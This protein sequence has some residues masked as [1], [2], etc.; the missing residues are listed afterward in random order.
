MIAIVS[1]DAGGAE[2][3]SSYIKKY[4][5]NYLFVL[6]G[7]AVSIFQKKIGELEI[8]SLKDALK[9]AEEILTGTSWQSDLEKRA[10]LLARK[11]GKRSISFLDHWVNYKE[12]FIFQNQVTLPDEIWTGDDDAFQLA[13]KIFPETLIRRKENPYFE[14][15]KNEL[16]IYKKEKKS[17]EGDRIL[18]VCE[19]IKDHGAATKA[20]NGA[21]PWGFTEEDA[22]L[23]FFKHLGKISGRMESCV[24]R[25]HPSDPIG[26]Y[27]WILEKYPDQNLRITN[28]KPL[29]QQ[30]MEADIIVGCESMAMVVGVIAGKKVIS[31]IPP[32]GKKLSLPQ[33]DI[34]ELRFINSLR[35]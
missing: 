10:I 18:F 8:L 34:V 16:T 33:K 15:L 27:D 7:P 9:K 5:G 6:D 17:G 30:V 35:I 26:K 31:C 24:F 32:E 29:L 20:T 28:Q 4:P 12:R 21:D 3:L 25:P 11:E 14:S 23:Y 13:Q 1:H 19:N 2:V 22:I